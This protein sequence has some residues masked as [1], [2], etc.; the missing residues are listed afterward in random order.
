MCHVLD[1]IKTLILT[2]KIYKALL[3][4]V[5]FQFS[6]PINTLTHNGFPLCRN[7]TQ[8]WL[9]EVV[10][11]V[12]SLQYQYNNPVNNTRDLCNTINCCDKL[13]AIFFYYKLYQTLPMYVRFQLNLHILR[14]TYSSINSSNNS[15]NIENFLLNFSRSCANIWN[16]TAYNR[17]QINLAPF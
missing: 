17:W 14:Q 12:V 4:L 8:F 16:M 11:K 15:E 10:S 7:A 5:Y 2:R 3:F 6:K 9:K 13:S 1:I